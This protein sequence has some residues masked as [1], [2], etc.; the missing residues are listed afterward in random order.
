MADRPSSAGARNGSTSRSTSRPESRSRS[1]SRIKVNSGAKE[2]PNSEAVARTRSSRRTNSAVGHRNAN[3]KSAGS[4]PSAD[5]SPPGAVSQV[6]LIE[7]ALSEQANSSLRELVKANRRRAHLI[8]LVAGLFASLPLGVGAGIILALTLGTIAGAVLSLVAWILISFALASWIRSTATKSALGL[9]GARPA[10][11]NTCPRLYNVVDGLCATYGLRAPKIMIVEDETANACSFGIDS[12]DASLVVTTGLVEELGLLETEGVVAHE[13][14]HMKLRDTAV[15]SVS[16][17]VLRYVVGDRRRE[18]MLSRLIGAG[19]E[20]QAD[21][22]AVKAI[23]YP[24]GLRSALI[25]IRSIGLLAQ[26][27]LLS[28][29]PTAWTRQVW[30]NSQAR[31]VDVPVPER[32]RRAVDPANLDLNIVSTIESTLDSIDVRVDALGEY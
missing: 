15:F 11:A 23:R 28:R 21:Q 17:S 13:L 32:A 24:P 14:V 5:K 9:I 2:R 1:N 7:S 27:S 29:P 30:I 18:R 12:R 4:R 6:D 26:P 22:M 8:A 25:E 10:T 3:A 16:V 31:S 20:F 19:R